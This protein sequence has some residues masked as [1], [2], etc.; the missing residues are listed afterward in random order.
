MNYH[1]AI[2]QQLILVIGFLF[3]VKACIIELSY[4]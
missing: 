3:A 1:S 4:C 2:T